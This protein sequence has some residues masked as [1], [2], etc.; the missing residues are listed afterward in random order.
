[1]DD[2]IKKQYE[3]MDDATLVATWAKATD[4]TTRRM[5]ETGT[6]YNGIGGVYNHSDF[7]VA[8]HKIELLENEM[9]KRG[10]TYG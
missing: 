5:Q 6:K 10:V 3:K 8:L 1:M 2:L 7:E 9:Q 4:W